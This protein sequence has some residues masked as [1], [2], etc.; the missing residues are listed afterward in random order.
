MILDKHDRVVI[1]VV[2][3]NGG[4]DGQLRKIKIVLLRSMQQK[5]T[6]KDSNI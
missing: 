5:A 1:I 2:F 4:L 6:N 3:S